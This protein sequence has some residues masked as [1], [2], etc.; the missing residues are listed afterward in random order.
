MSSRRAWCVKRGIDPR[1]YY[2][3]V[4]MRRRCRAV[5]RATSPY[6]VAKGISVVSSWN[7]FSAFSADMAPHPGKGWSL[8]RKNNSQGYSKKNCVWAN[9]SAQTRNRSFTKLS[10]QDVVEI[11]RRYIP[12]SRWYKSPAHQLLLAKEFGVSKAMISRIIRREDWVNV[13]QYR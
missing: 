7:I 1:L 12:G 6:Y 4:E 10:E 11:R 13:R 8:E 2:A 9:P 3:W 5:N